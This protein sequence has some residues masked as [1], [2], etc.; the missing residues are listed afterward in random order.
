MFAFNALTVFASLSLLA[1]TL[2]QAWKR[3][4]YHSLS[5]YP[6]PRLAA[7]TSWYRAYYDIVKDGGW[8]EHLEHL[9]NRYGT[10]IRVGLNELHFSDPRAYNEIYGIGTRHIKQPQ[11]YS[12]FSTDKSVFAMF[13]HHE[14]MQRRNLIGPFFS[15]RAILNLEK[16]VQTKIDLLVS[17][18]L[19]YTPRKQSA[20][21]DLAFRATSLEVIT[22]YCFAKSSNALD[23]ENF[24][25][26]ILIAIDQTLPMIWVFKHFPLI[27][28]ILLG[29]PECFASVLKPSTTGILEQRRQMGS[30]IDEILKD[31]TS[32]HS[33]DHETIYHHFLTPQPDNERLPPIN[34][35]WLLDEGLYL[36]FA[37]SDTVGNT[38]TV[39]AYYILNN[40]HVH[41]KL[42]KTLVEAW[43][44][45]DTPASYE[46]LERL[47]YLTAVI[48][49]SLRMAHGVVSPLPRIVGPSD[50][51]I[52]GEVIPAGTVVSMGAPI[53]H[54]N[55]EIFP[56][57]LRFEPE[58]WLKDDS[59][60]LEKYLV[61]FSKGPRGCLG[62]NLAW[63]ELY[64][65]IG[66]VFRKLDLTPDN[67]SIENVSFRE[68]F[69]PIHRG[70]HF[71]A[72]VAPTSQ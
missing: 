38:C 42:F 22:S 52:S 2:S 34:R 57:P 36:R 26:E 17:R 70:R 33:V 23:S 15:R 35:D 61:A 10:I 9:H 50:A 11:M 64:L 55:P 16:T 39:A 62:I 28:R 69:V 47:S 14:V 71:H 19:E 4:Y 63:C 49:E 44:D 27:K 7:L 67:P 18:L 72:F 59:A 12:C 41:R 32:L 13:D 30:Q 45:K 6:G 24:Q 51:E 31:P 60:E 29:I 48:K 1:V 68:Y 25:N 5:R 58:R 40:K 21:L 46:T 43:P 20:N 54:R 3:L 56:D 37:G 65:I 8:S 66:T 53:V